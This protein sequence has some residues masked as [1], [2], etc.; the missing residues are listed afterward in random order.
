ME[1]Q[2]L[3]RVHFMRTYKLQVLG[4]RADAAEGRPEAAPGPGGEAAAPLPGRPRDRRAG[5]HGA[6]AEARD[7]VRV[8]DRQVGGRQGEGRRQGRQGV[9]YALLIGRLR[10]L[11][12]HS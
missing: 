5:P 4:R 10:T 9:R 8:A 7:P 12:Y 3:I 1:C 11:E 2:R 6:G